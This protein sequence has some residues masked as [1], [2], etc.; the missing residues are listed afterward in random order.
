M[1]VIEIV[2]VKPEWSD[3]NNLTYHPRPATLARAPGIHVSGILKEL[4]LQQNLFTNEDR[5]DEM[6]LRI[7]LGLGFEEAAARLYPTMMWQPGELVFNGIAGNPDGLDT[8]PSTWVIPFANT[9]AYHQYIQDWPTALCV[10]EFKYT[11]KSQRVKGTK[12]QPDGTF[13]PEDLKDIR[14][15]WMW[16]QQGMSYIN[17]YRKTNNTFAHIQKLNLCR[18]HICWKFGTYTYPQSEVYMR[19]L[20]EFTEAELNGNWAMLMAF[21][22]GK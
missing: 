6:P 12:P 10:D 22:G 11:G 4:A 13:R 1:K 15:E 8:V 17:L 21:K 9:K 5:D 3:L 7:L 20:V 2:E 16:M 18:F 19:Y 14:T